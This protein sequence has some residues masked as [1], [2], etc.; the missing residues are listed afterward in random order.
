MRPIL[1][2]GFNAFG[3][4]IENPSK[5]IVE[6]VAKRGCV[7]D[8]ATAILPTEYAASGDCIRRLIEEIKP[9]AVV[10]LGVAAKRAEIN[11]ERV[12]LNLNDASI[13]DNAGDLALDRAIA[14]DGPMAYRS[15]LPLAAMQMALRERGIPVVISNHAG[16]YV[17]NHTFYTVRHFIESAGLN[18]PCGFI[19]VPAIVEPGNEGAPG[20]P[21]ATM[22]EAVEVCL[23][24]MQA[25]TVA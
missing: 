6:A 15:T 25:A 7:P 21:L 22:V 13:P 11:L 18:I 23:G 20:L 3:D 9:G 2:T 12:A 10:C 24:V 19:H 14:D 5:L 17:C 16:A 8:V 1:L 4:L